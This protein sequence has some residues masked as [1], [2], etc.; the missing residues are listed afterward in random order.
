[1]PARRMPSTSSQPKPSRRSI[2]RTRRVTSSG[3]G[4]GTTTA[5][6]PVLAR[7][8]AMSSMLS[9][10]RRKSSS[11]TMVS[12]NSST[13]AGGLASAA[14]GIRPIRRGASQLMAAMSRSHQARH[15]GPLHLDH[16]FFAGAQAGGVD[17]GDR[18][19]SDRGGLEVLE[20]RLQ[21][22]GPGRP[23]PPA[24]TTSKRS[25]GTRS[26]SSLNSLTSS[27]GNTPS[28]EERIWPSL[29]YVGPRR[30]NALRRR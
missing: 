13:R 7:T 15:L 9:A 28:P 27:G 30:S 12:A 23:R 29:M 2:T 25:A 17:L 19:G 20:D 16:H 3:C 4:R 1:M 24:R 5:F 22:A 10:S 21:A 11:S 14:T 26:R 18:R 8:A 6:W